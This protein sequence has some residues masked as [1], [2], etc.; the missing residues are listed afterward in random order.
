MSKPRFIRGAMAVVASLVL[1]AA[2][3]AMNSGSAAAAGTSGCG[4]TPTLTSGTHT[5]QSSGKNR[6]FILRI[7]ANY[8]NN[9]PYRLMF[10]IHWLN[11]TMN[12]VDSGGSSGASWSYYGQ[13]QLAN[14]TAI[15]ISPQGLNNGWANSNGEDVTLFDDIMRRVEADLCV[16]PSLRFAMGFSYGGGMSYSLACSRANVFRAVAVFAGAQ[17]SGCS[18]G[19]QPIAYM[20]LHGITDNVLNISQG[21]SLRDRFVRNNGCTAQ[22]PPEP[23]SGSRSHI[24]TAYSGCQAGYPVVWAAYDNGHTPAPVDGTYTENGA[25][26]WT[27]NEVWKFFSQFQST[28]GPNP[29]PSPSPSPSASPS[30]TPSPS[31]STSFRLRN[32]AAGR[33]IDSPNSASANGTLLQIYDCHTNPNQ[34]FTYGSGR[35]QTLGKCLDSPTNAGSGTRV[36]LWDC[37]TNSNQQWTFN[38]NGTVTSNANNLCL[39]VTGT[40]NSATVTVA[41]CNGQATQ[42]WT[43][44]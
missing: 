7:P 36:Q 1:L 20:G 26:T 41:S 32:E 34:I 15:F 28:S 29:S 38:S 3:L 33:C 6:Q 35:L 42:R 21:R 39:N 40:G 44:A 22:N 4:K 10:G 19:S 27:K 2:H 17:L 9:T 23:G 5:I 30:P 43:R 13:R 25:Q 37:H 8:N 16:D 31:P 11:G 14:N 24:V 12:D 18:G